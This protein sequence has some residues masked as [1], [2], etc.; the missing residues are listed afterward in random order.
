M[1]ERPS[2]GGPGWGALDQQ[3]GQERIW[4]CLPW[5]GGGTEGR[6][7]PFPLLSEAPPPQPRTGSHGEGATPGVPAGCGEGRA[8]PQYFL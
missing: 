2:H 4:A 5:R 6:P 3:A 1:V 8:D 7:S